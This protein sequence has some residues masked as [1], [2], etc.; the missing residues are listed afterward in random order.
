MHQTSR[1]DH[2]RAPDAGHH[3]A[4]LPAELPAEFPAERPTDP[5]AQARVR[6]LKPAVP[7]GVESP[8]PAAADQRAEILTPRLRLR[9]L[10]E[11]DRDAFCAL[12]D[13]SRAHLERFLPLAA[14]DQ[15]ASE[16]FERQLELTIAG[17]E[18]GKAFRRVAADRDT[19]ELVGA[20]NLVVI[21]RGLEWDADVSLWLAAGCTGK[22][23][24][25]EG[26]AALLSYSFADLPAG[27][28]LHAIHGFIAPDNTASQTLAAGFGFQRAEGATTHL[29]VGDRWQLHEKWSLPI[30]RWQ[31]LA[32]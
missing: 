26:F 20:F 16:V 24:A 8:A 14:P 7:V 5:P 11:H 23:L 29:T 19:G 28:G 10:A 25:S 13:A 18:S 32:G 12:L 30:T 21:R 15:P 1:A 31:T 27:L 17:D 6:P 4:E 22:G 3:P 2:R 9:P